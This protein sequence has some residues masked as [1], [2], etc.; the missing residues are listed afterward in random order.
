M[1]SHFNEHSSDKGIW[2]HKKQIFIVNVLINDEKREGKE[3]HFVVSCHNSEENR[4]IILIT[5]HPIQPWEYYEYIPIVHEGCLMKWKC[6][7]WLSI[8]VVICHSSSFVVTHCVGKSQTRDNYRKIL[9]NHSQVRVF[10]GWLEKNFVRVFLH[11]IEVFEQSIKCL[12]FS[13]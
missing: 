3:N 5:F 11:W 13:L 4:G 1:V 6:V 12:S 2:F 8:F 10:C 7:K 9:S